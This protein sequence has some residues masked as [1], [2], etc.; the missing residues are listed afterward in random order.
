MFNQ[1]SVSRPLMIGPSSFS[2]LVSMLGARCWKEW[3]ETNEKKSASPRSPYRYNRKRYLNIQEKKNLGTTEYKQLNTLITRC[4]WS[5]WSTN[6]SKFAAS[7]AA[8]AALWLVCFARCWWIC[9]SLFYFLFSLTWV[10]H[11]GSVEGLSNSWCVLSWEVQPFRVIADGLIRWEFPIV[12]SMAAKG[13]AANKS[14]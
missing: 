7:A 11:L 10:L 2:L 8:A 1:S 5:S 14:P 4:H 6:H 9:A 12:N 3:N 13:F